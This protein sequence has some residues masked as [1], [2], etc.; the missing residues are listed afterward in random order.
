MPV[1]S[2]CY[3]III[4]LGISAPEHGT[5]VVDG[6]NAVDK[7][8]IYQ[9][10]STVQ[11][12]GSKIFDSQ[13]QMHTGTQKYYVSLD[14]EFQEHLTKIHRKDGVIDQVKSKCSQFNINKLVYSK[15]NIYHFIKY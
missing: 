7:R 3:S 11:L 12:P 15:K 10:I 6:L 13:I 4:D 2:Q 1:L 5:E 14:K 8:Y 9:L